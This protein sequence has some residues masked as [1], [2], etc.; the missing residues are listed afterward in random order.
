MKKLILF[1]IDGTLIY[2]SKFHDYSFSVAF[3]KVYG[4]D[5]TIDKT[6]TA[7]KTDK[8]III[9]VLKEK[10]VP[11][12]KIYS[13]LER[14]YSV[15]VNYCRK[16]IK[17]DPLIKLVP[18]VKKFILRLKKDGH[19]LG[20]V[21]GNLEGIAK[22]K[23]RRVG[24]LDFFEL[25][26]FGELSEIRSQLVKKAISLV[27]KKFKVRFKRDN[28]YIV[29]DTP[30]DIECGKVN[31]VK[32]I[33]VATKYYSKEELSKFKPDFLFDNFL[34]TDDLIDAIEG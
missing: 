17:S 8:R 9:E 6:L 32:T 15:M 2:G 24:L 27:Q 23:L 26:A 21:T 13:N 22:L 30:L 19:I 10:G 11:E 4:V 3:K 12:T 5:A 1:D 31:K 18:N 16:N 34:N 33:A 29:G 28:V 7:G 25:G 14:A 20:L